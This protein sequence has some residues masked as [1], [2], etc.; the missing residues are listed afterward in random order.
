MQHLEAAS[1]VPRH[2][3]AKELPRWYRAMLADCPACK[4]HGCVARLPLRDRLWR[5]AKRRDPFWGRV[6]LRARALMR[7]AK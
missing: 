3:R 4:G 5:N 2:V 6:E 7:G 1:P